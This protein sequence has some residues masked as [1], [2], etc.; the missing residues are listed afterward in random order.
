MS[1]ECPRMPACYVNV[2]YFVI[3]YWHLF[4]TD[5]KCTNTSAREEASVNSS[6]TYGSRYAHGGKS[7]T[8]WRCSILEKK[9]EIWLNPMTN[10]ILKRGK[11]HY[12]KKTPPKSSITQRLRTDLGRSC[13]WSYYSHPT[14][15]FN[16]LTGQNFP[17]PTTAVQ[18]KGAHLKF[19][20]K[21]P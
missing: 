7:N 10:R 20:N 16:R 18:S 13:S 3:Q 12:K 11:W 2:Y 15:V 8:L 19:V 1:N 17:L 14:Y 4:G 5:S 9:E 21:P 6:Q